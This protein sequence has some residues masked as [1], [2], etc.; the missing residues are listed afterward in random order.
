MARPSASSL[1]RRDPARMLFILD[2]NKPDELRRPAERRPADDLPF[3]LPRPTHPTRPGGVG[4]YGP[5]RT[6]EVTMAL[7]R[8]VRLAGALSIVLSAA[9]SDASSADGEVVEK[10]VQNPSQTESAS[11][12]AV[13]VSDDGARLIV[14]PQ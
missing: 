7:S 3:N 13:W 8:H 14:P 6:T 2:F 5:A 12:L 9:A 11:L 10:G 1:V 4:A